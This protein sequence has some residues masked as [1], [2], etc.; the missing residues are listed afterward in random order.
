M[1]LFY[2]VSG[3]FF[4]TWKHAELQF[5]PVLRSSLPGGNEAN[6]WTAWH[7]GAIW[8]MDGGW[9]LQHGIDVGLMYVMLCSILQGCPILT[10]SLSQ[11][12][13]E[14]PWSTHVHPT[15]DDDCENLSA[16]CGW[17]AE[18]LVKPSQRKNICSM[19][20]SLLYCLHSLWWCIH[21]SYKCLFVLIFHCTE[22]D[23]T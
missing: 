21:T 7:R 13:L 2:F 15:E 23:W 12:F 19:D 14:R 9:G 6:T 10:D 4:H 20:R 5:Q 17:L 1:I 16:R 22:P 11:I 18:G 3:L 8:Q